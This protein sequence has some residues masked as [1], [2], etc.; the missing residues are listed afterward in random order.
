MASRP[1]GLSDVL[2]LKT[3]Y[4]PLKLGFDHHMRSPSPTET[5]QDKDAALPPRAQPD[6]V[7]S[8]K[9]AARA[10]EQISLS[11]PLAW[12]AKRPRTPDRKRSPFRGA[13]AAILHALEQ[14]VR[15]FGGTELTSST[16]LPLMLGGR[17][18]PNAPEPDDPGVTL[19]FMR[20]GE[21]YVVAIDAWNSVHA[22]LRD[23]QRLVGTWRTLEA[24]GARALLERELAKHADA[25]R[26]GLRSR[27]LQPMRL[28]AP[29]RAHPLPGSSRTRTGDD[30]S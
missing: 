22:N 8:A 24:R 5:A 23:C 4:S 19:T 14:E 15:D 6:T 7:R 29:T 21:R 10:A 30:Q 11:Y 13:V 28:I 2:R 25:D 3:N 12:P 9:A 27:P 16:N 26:S 17:L 18:S 1:S 20:N